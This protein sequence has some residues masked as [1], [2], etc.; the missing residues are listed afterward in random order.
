MATTDEIR[1]ALAVVNDRLPGAWVTSIGEAGAEYFDHWYYNSEVGGENEGLELH[2]YWD[3]GQ[4]YRIEVIRVEYF[5]E[6]HKYH[7]DSRSETV[8]ERASIEGSEDDA[9]A[10]AIEIMRKHTGDGDTTDNE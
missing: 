1:E 8:I 3:K 10:K 6:S 2:Q 9:D 5:P 7:G 4:P